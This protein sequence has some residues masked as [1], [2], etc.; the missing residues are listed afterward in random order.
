MV[1]L[2]FTKVKGLVVKLH[3]CHSKMSFNQTWCHSTL[4]FWLVRLPQVQ[5]CH[6][7]EYV[8]WTYWN[9][10]ARIKKWKL[11][12]LIL[13]WTSIYFTALTKSFPAKWKPQIL[14]NLTHNRVSHVAKYKTGHF[15]CPAIYKTGFPVSCLCICREAKPQIFQRPK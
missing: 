8:N 6:S 4:K 5:K 1:C 14:S 3:F 13:V 12:A 2:L 9:L 15:M 7:W 10:G 11:W